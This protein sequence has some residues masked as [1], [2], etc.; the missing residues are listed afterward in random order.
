MSGR[1]P[2]RHSL[3]LLLEY[4]SIGVV[5]MWEARSAPGT[6]TLRNVLMAKKT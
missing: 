4:Y 6:S 1:L 2:Q 3:R 5:K